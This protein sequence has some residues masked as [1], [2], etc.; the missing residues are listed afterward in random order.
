[1]WHSG[2]PCPTRADSELVLGV[3]SGLEQRV[4]DMENL[5]LYMFDRMMNFNR[6]LGLTVV[7]LIVY[8]ANSAETQFFRCPKKLA[9][10]SFTK[11]GKRGLPARRVSWG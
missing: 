5:T 9:A 11:F 10:R 1:M 4:V 8:I 3:E 2:N 6:T 7:G